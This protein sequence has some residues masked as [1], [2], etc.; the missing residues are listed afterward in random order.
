MQIRTSSSPLHFSKRERSG[1]IL[2]VF[3]DI[4]LLFLPGFLKR[5]TATREERNMLSK[6]TFDAKD[7]LQHTFNKYPKRNKENEAQ[8][9]IHAKPFEFDPNVI[10]SMTWLRLGVSSKTTQT[11]I[12]Y[13]VKGGKFRQPEDL[14]KIWGMSTILADQLM[15]YVRIE[16]SI[17][18]SKFVPSTTRFEKKA[19]PVIDLNYADSAM[20]ELLPGIGPVLAARIVSY[21]KKL[22][23]FITVMQ[24]KEVWGL[25]DSVYQKIATRLEVNA[26]EVT[27]MDINT[28]DWDKL[29]SHPY[30]GYSLA[31]TIIRYRNQ[32]G[33][34]KTLKDIQ[35]ILLIDEITYNKL[36]NYFKVVSEN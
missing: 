16:K 17:E 28:A 1:I 14:K 26:G 8:V 13:R 6:I 20:F 19:L 7:S 12:N 10:D 5:D 18:H 15:P 33:K 35:Q 11:I 27:K 3:V 30:I 34:F 36:E 25:Q 31:K 24:L 32:H 22:G 9:E 4:I 21:R 23:G 29:K 2:I